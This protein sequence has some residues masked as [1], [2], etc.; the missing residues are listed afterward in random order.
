MKKLEL[1]LMSLAILMG[2][3]IQAQWSLEDLVGKWQINESDNYESWTLVSPDSLSGIGFRMQ[4]GEKKISEYLSITIKDGLWT[5]RARVP[6]QNEGQT[7]SFKGR[8]NEDGCRIFENPDHD[9]PQS[10][11]YCLSE[12]RFHVTVSGSSGSGFKLILNKPD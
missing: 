8:V 5:Y 7:I 2:S 12:N 4:D 3:S 9:F 11:E 6:N 10:I 1:I